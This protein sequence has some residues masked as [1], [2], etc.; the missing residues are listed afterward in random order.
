MVHEKVIQP[1][2]NPIGPDGCARREEGVAI[3]QGNIHESS[4]GLVGRKVGSWLHISYASLA[5]ALLRERG[6]QLLIQTSRI[7]E[8]LC[9]EGGNLVRVGPR[10]LDEP[11]APQVDP[12]PADA[13]LERS[14]SR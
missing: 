10:A 3:A 8:D 2:H 12:C 9:S 13:V 6:E 5:L 1:L 4:R 11:C 14:L 7:R